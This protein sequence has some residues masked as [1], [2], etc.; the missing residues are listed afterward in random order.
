MMTSQAVA[1]TPHTPCAVHV[2]RGPQSPSPWHDQP[3]HLPVDR[4]RARVAAM[5][6]ARGN[7]FDRVS[8]L[9]DETSLTASAQGVRQAR[10]HHAANLSQG[11]LGCAREG[12]G[13]VVDTRLACMGCA[14]RPMLRSH[15]YDRSL[16]S[17]CV[18]HVPPST[19]SIRSPAR[20]TQGS[21]QARRDCMASVTSTSACMI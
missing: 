9:R 12:V 18:E 19:T 14:H 11:T 7:R 21:A 13:V 1:A 4:G 2:R 17:P 15:A 5:T 20:V 8:A 16:Q 6:H 3:T 10:L